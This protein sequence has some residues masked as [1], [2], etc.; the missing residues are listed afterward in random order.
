MATQT[1][2]IAFCA[3]CGTQVPGRFCPSCGTPSPSAEAQGQAVPPAPAPASPEAAGPPREPSS[4]GEQRRW[5]PAALVAGA[6][7]VVAAIVAVL[8]VTVG[9]DPSDAGTKKSARVPALSAV[10]LAGQDFYQPRQGQGY[11]VLA[12]AGWAVT[13]TKLSLPFRAATVFVSPQEKR[14][15]LTAGV[16]RDKTGP[17]ARAARTLTPDLGAGARVQQSRQTVFAGARKAW[18]VNFTTS[19]GRTQVLYLFDACGQRYAVVGATEPA[20][21]DGVK[22]RFGLAASSL[23]AIC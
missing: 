8:L 9:G 20:R 4:P 2:P 17:L 12:P 18:R 11:L 19:D 22:A 23:Q 16:L 1:P 5:M 3:Q 15:S 7:A 6:V 10:S 21:M 14:T 13:R